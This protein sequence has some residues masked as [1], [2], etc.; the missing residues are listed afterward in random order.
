[1]EAGIFNS[2]LFTKIYTHSLVSLNK[3]EELNTKRQWPA[4]SFK[5]LS[6]QYF[7]KDSHRIIPQVLIW[8]HLWACLYR[9]PVNVGPPS[10]KLAS[11]NC[12][13]FHAPEHSN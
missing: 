1:M 9:L 2:V 12:F 4:H 3:R 8:Q 10:R 13:C 11:P 6:S 5:P 7:T